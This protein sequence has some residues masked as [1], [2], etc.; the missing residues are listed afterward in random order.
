MESKDSINKDLIKIKTA[1]S[2]ELKQII[3]LRSNQLVAANAELIEKDK[4][5]KRLKFKILVYK[6]ALIGSAVAY[7]LFSI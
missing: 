6:I 7:F 4:L 2:N 3:E 1:Q 5:I